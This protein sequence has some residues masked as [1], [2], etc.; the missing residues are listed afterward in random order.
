MRK[1]LLI[2]FGITVLFII[3]L[4][5]PLSVISERSDFKHGP[6]ITVD[7]EDYYLAGIQDDSTDATDIPGH[8]WIQTAPDR[9]KGKQFNTGPFGKSKWWSSDADDGQLLYVINGIIDAWSLEKSQQYASEGYVHYHVLISVSDGT[10]HPDMVV[11]LQHTS[12][13]FFTLDGGPHPEYGH[14][15]SPGIDYE[16]I[17]NYKMPYNP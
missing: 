12:R 16:F 1:K 8:T 13:L 15:V 3:S 9:L 2:V 5:A 14:E 10:P 11:W 17:P 7:G 4:I 6:T